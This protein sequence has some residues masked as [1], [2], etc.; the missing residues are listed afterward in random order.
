MLIFKHLPRS[1]KIRTTLQISDSS[2]SLRKIHSNPRE[3]HFLSFTTA[4]TCVPIEACPGTGG[5]AEGCAAGPAASAGTRTQRVFLLFGIA[6]RSHARAT[7]SEPRAYPDARANRKLERQMSRRRL[8]TIERGV[9]STG[10]TGDSFLPVASSCEPRRG[11][12]SRSC[13][14]GTRRS[15]GDCR[16]A[17]GGAASA[18]SPA[19]PPRRGWPPGKSS[20]HN[21]TK[22][23]TAPPCQ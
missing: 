3:K 21:S 6:V 12:P 16:R 5:G 18:P 23:L 13:R 4:S 19:P 15:R 22:G 2:V 17:C 20:L 1:T 11:P 8:M 7:P 9:S 14:R 10:S